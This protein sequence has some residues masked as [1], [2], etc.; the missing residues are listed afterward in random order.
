MRRLWWALLLVL[1][2]TS[3]SAQTVVYN[4][5][6]IQFISLDHETLVTSYVVEYWLN[7]VDPAT[8]SPYTTST[9][10]K[11]ALT[12]TGVAQTYTALLTALTPFPAIQVGKTYRATVRSV[13]ATLEETSARSELSDP[14]ALRS[15]PQP[16]QQVSFH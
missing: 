15:V 7:G 2:A 12:G 11:A 8:G 3:A 4:P 9:L 14:F 6:R 5:E 16:P 13:G 10:P 1:V